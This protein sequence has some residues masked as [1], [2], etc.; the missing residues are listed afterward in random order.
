MKNCLAKYGCH[1]NVKFMQ[2]ILPKVSLCRYTS[3]DSR[4]VHTNLDLDSFRY[5]SKTEPNHC[6]LS[7]NVLQIGV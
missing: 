6:E 5:H 2:Y 4:R 7:S 3:G 1:G